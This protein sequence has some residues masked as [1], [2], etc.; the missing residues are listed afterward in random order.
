MGNSIAMPKLRGSL[1]PA[2]FGLGFLCAWFYASFLSSLF[3]PPPTYASVNVG[4]L[5]WIFFQ[6]GS[7]VVFAA[8]LG[9]EKRFGQ[10]SLKGSVQAGALVCMLVGEG[11]VIFSSTASE[12]LLPLVARPLGAFISSAGLAPLLIAWGAVFGAKSADE[13]EGLIPANLL[14][15][16]VLTLVAC[17]LGGF[18]AAGLRMLFSVISFVLLRSEW[19]RLDVGSVVGRLEAVRA[20]E[21]SAENGSV[22]PMLNWRTL[23]PL[24]S[25]F[26]AF[27]VLRA[28]TMFDGVWSTPT[29]FIE[30]FIIGAIAAAL[31]A[32]AFLFYSKKITFFSMLRIVCPLMCASLLVLI[33]A[34][35]SY[36]SIAFSAGLVA[37]LCL[38]V[39]V[40]V[41]AAALVRTAQQ[42]CTTALGWLRLALPL[43][44]LVGLLVL[45]VF[46][47]VP[48][49]VML[50]CMIVA[51][52][53]AVMVAVPDPATVHQ[54]AARASDKDATTVDVSP[55]DGYGARCTQLSKEYGLSSREQDVLMLLGKG[56]DVPYIREKLL[57]SRNT[58]NT[59]IRHIYQKMDIH[60]KQELLDELEYD[61][62]HG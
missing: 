47:D 31:I 54:L 46:P 9:G 20:A 49:A 57:I 41:E 3:A 32:Y 52:F 7:V 61:E 21:V 58:V 19:K 17:A 18:L 15:A 1:R 27:T 26:V 37:Y 51:L 2:N 24:V 59:H 35:A 48:A 23:L 53:M 11:L 36:A 33:V 14:L 4:P 43:G 25:V 29:R 6:L 22:V 12:G 62:T 55:E 60:S 28:T 44:A 34:P 30:L 13:A 42:S 38:D 39:F 16:M 50:S 56:R 10:L 8:L 5:S 40:W 45:K